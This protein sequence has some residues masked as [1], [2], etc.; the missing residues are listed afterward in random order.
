MC[1]RVTVLGGNNN[2][3]VQADDKFLQEPAMLLYMQR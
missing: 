2:K 3:G 1:M